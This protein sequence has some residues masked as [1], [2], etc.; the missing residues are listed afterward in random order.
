MIVELPANVDWTTAMQRLSTLPKQATWEELTARYQQADP[1]SAS[2]E[3]W[4][5]M[6][7]IFH[8]YE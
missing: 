4:Q 3:K 2:A 5:L 6:E 1:S 7:R 8:L